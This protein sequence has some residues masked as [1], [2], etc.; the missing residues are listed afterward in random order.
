MAVSGRQRRYTALLECEVSML[1]LIE[2]MVSANNRAVF[3][4]DIDFCCERSRATFDHNANG[5][6]TLANVPTPANTC[7][8]RVCSGVRT[9]AIGPPGARP[10]ALTSLS[11]SAYAVLSSC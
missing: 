3:T 1:S 4:N 11:A 6:V 8:N 5:P 2:A 10:T 7:A 9:G